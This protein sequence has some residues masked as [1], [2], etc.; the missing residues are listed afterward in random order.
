MPTAG[1]LSHAYFPQ[2]IP[3]REDDTATPFSLVLDGPLIPILNLRVPKLFVRRGT[4]RGFDVA[5]VG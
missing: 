3:I 5:R 1:G 2:L 4:Q